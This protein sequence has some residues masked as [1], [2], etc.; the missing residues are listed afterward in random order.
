M[1]TSTSTRRARSVALS[2]GL[3]VCT[4]FACGGCKKAPGE[5]NGAQPQVSSKAVA[6]G[7]TAA[8]N[9]TPP[10]AKL[11]LAGVDTSKLTKREHRAWTRLV[12]ELLAPCPAVAVSVAQ[13]VTEKRDCAACTP[14]ARY[15]AELVQAGRGK[16]D[17]RDM[18][19]ARFHPD[20]KKTIVVGDSPSVGPVAALVTIVEFADFECPACGQLSRPLA[21]LQQAHHDKIRLVFKHYPLK[22]HHPHA[23]LAAQAAVAAQKQG[24]FWK[25]AHVMFDNQDKLTESDLLAYAK[26]IGLDVTSFG[27]DLASQ[28]VKDRVAQ[29]MRQGDSLGLPGT[30]SVYVNGRLADMQALPQWIAL[31]LELVGAK[32]KPAGATSAASVTKPA[33]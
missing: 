30:P 8:S 22:A 24:Q 7:K 19:K 17:A 29:D 6:S 33:P 21:A 20:A 14:A 5:Q 28:G 25:M 31:E 16:Q 26:K 27:A 3:A 13:C 15:V 9:K 4:V 10:L 32:A 1:T 12:R 2:L 23:M 11:E 18:Y